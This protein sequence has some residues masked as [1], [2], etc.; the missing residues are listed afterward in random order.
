MTHSKSP[1]SQ[2]SLGHPVHFMLPWKPGS[3][4]IAFRVMH[5]KHAG[6][7]NDISWYGGIDTR[8]RL[9]GR[10]TRFKPKANHY[11]FAVADT[12]HLNKTHTGST[13]KS[14]C[15]T[16]KVSDQTSEK[17]WKSRDEEALTANC[18]FFLTQLH[19][20]CRHCLLLLCI[21]FR[22]LTFHVF[23]IFWFA[24]RV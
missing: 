23:H 17:S 8:Q 22:I 19:L 9:N 4:H 3:K 21:F 24:T 16:I 18:T 1:S 5:P 14:C 7:D 2:H 20:H 15:L 10:A 6:N 13:S 12:L 11:G